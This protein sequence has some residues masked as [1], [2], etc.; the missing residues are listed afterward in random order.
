MFPVG[1]VACRQQLILVVAMVNALLSAR[2]PQ[3]ASLVTAPL[4]WSH[5]P[6]GAPHGASSTIITSSPLNDVPVAS[7]HVP[8]ASASQLRSVPHASWVVAPAGQIASKKFSLF[9]SPHQAHWLPPHVPNRTRRSGSL[10]APS[11]C[12]TPSSTRA[13]I[14]VDCK[15]RVMAIPPMLVL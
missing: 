15:N 4:P 3:N 12:T 2:C 1:A 13:R 8:P 11:E 9:G 5:A 7:A 10:R 14:A 6:V